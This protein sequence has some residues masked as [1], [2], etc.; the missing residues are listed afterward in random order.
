MTVL[1][2]QQGAVLAVGDQAVGASDV[3]HVGCGVFDHGADAALTQQ[4]F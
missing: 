3:E 4:P 2:G 1:A